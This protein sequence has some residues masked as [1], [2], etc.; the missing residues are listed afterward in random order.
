MP[1][2]PPVSIEPCEVI[3]MIREVFQAS[4][5]EATRF[6][7]D[8]WLIGK[9]ELHFSN[10]RPQGDFPVD[11]IDWFSGVVVA[12]YSNIGKQRYPFRINRGKLA[13]I[14]AEYQNPSDRRSDAKQASKADIR[15]AIRAAYDQADALGSKPPN[16]NEIVGPV[17]TRLSNAGLMAS[18]NLIQ[19]LAAED[20]FKG[21]RLKP[22]HKR[23]DL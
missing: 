15:N 17:R 8:L 23:S 20:E 7:S 18:K 4:E 2:P 14:L 12:L 6:L 16:V 3:H 5:A 22:G 21:R 9:L 10:R 19:E 13:D 11:Q 1:I